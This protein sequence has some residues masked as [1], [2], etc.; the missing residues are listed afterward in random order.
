MGTCST[1]RQAEVGVLSPQPWRVTGWRAPHVLEALLFTWG[2]AWLTRTQ[3]RPEDSSAK[4]KADHLGQ[5]LPPWPKP[6]HPR[7]SCT[8]A[9]HRAPK[10]GTCQ[11]RSPRPP[12]PSVHH[13]GHPPQQSQHENSKTGYPVVCSAIPLLQYLTHNLVTLTYMNSFF[14]LATWNGGTESNEQT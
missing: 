12:L 10:A 11:D 4:G 3:A 8:R 1:P 5:G 7:I 2:V 14:F 6:S 13:A 9:H